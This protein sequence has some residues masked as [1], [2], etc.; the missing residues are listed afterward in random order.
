MRRGNYSVKQGGVKP[1][2][3]KPLRRSK[4]QGKQAPM[5]SYLSKSVVKPMTRGF[6]EVDGE[7]RKKGKGERG[8]EIMQKLIL[9]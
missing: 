6:E 7:T 1:G 9:N 8:Q 5:T 3:Q 2:N 4:S